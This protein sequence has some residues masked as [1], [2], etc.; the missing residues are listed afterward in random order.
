MLKLGARE[1][2][3]RG[4][5]LL[6]AALYYRSHQKCLLEIEAAAFIRRITVVKFKTYITSDHHEQ[7]KHI[8][9]TKY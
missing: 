4:R 3:N 5:T 9:A 6:Q 2:R 7:S 8:F 1:K